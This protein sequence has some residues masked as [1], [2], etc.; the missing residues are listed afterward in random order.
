M[1]QINHV[2][3]CFPDWIWTAAPGPTEHFLP[4]P[5]REPGSAEQVPLLIATAL[6]LLGKHWQNPAQEYH[7]AFLQHFTNTNQWAQHHQIQQ[8]STLAPV[9]QKTGF[10]DGLMTPVGPALSQRYGVQEIQPFHPGP[11]KPVLRRQTPL[12]SLP[13]PPQELCYTCFLW[14]AGLGLSRC[15]WLPQPGMLKPLLG[16]RSTSV[17]PVAAVP[18]KGEDLLQPFFSITMDWRRF[19]CFRNNHSIM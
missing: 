7:L 6:F 11:T 12:S 16:V 9:L 15:Q 3:K 13:C 19:A 5:S 10:K 17:S 14:T 4:L 2:L 8:L 18:R 1:P